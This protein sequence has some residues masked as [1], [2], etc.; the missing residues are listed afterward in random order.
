MLW[1]WYRLKYIDGWLRDWVIN[2]I[3]FYYWCRLRVWFLNVVENWYWKVLYIDKILD[4]FENVKLLDRMLVKLVD[5][6]IIMSKY[7]L[8]F[9]NVEIC[10]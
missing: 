3:W 7:F 8:I 10:G 2:V 9:C 6:L 4:I 5:V 1:Y